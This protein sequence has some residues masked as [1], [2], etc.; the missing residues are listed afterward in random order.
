M[1][2]VSISDVHIKT[3]D[4]ERAGL[5]NK[6]LTSEDVKDADEVILLGDIFDLM[7]GNKPQYIEKYQ[8]IFTQIEELLKSGKVISY[9]EGN[10]DFHVKNLFRDWSKKIG[11]DDKFHFYKNAVIKKIG[12]TKVLYTHGDDIEIDNPSYKIYK[13]LINNKFLE[14]LGDYVVPYSTIE[15]IGHRASHNSRERNK[16]RYERSEESTIMIRDKFREAAR[17]ASKKYEVEMVI[18]GHSHVL[19]HFEESGLVYLNSGYAPLEM[20]YIVVQE[21]QLPEIK[22]II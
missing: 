7:V 19:D 8:E 20:S 12:E 14:L 22:K 18:C 1:K 11:Q 4:D 15:W 9:F 17:R 2:I 5:L 10:H 21:G 6:F 16:V 13:A 3:A